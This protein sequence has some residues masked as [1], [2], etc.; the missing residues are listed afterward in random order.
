MYININHLFSVMH[1]ETISIDALIDRVYNKSRHL[2]DSTD[3]NQIV[4]HISDIISN[5]FYQPVSVDYISDRIRKYGMWKEN[6][7]KLKT[8]PVIV[9]RSDDWYACRQTLITA[10]DFAQALGEGKFGTQKQF[11]MKKAGYDD[12]PFDSN[13][14]PL[15]WGIMFEPT[16]THIYS[17]RNNTYVAEFG[18]LRHPRV[19]FLGA[20]PDGIN[21]L[22]IMLEVKC[23]YKRKINGEVPGQYYFQIQGQLD[24]CDLDECDYLECEFACI[25]TFDELQEIIKCR[26]N[27]SNSMNSVNTSNDSSTTNV[28]HGVIVEFKD[29]SF[30]YG[31]VFDG[32]GGNDMSA[33]YIETFVNVYREKGCEI[34]AV[35]I[36]ILNIFNVIRVYKNNMYLNE[37]LPL[38]GSV[39][40][41][42]LRYRENKDIYITE[43]EGKGKDT[44]VSRPAYN[45][46]RSSGMGTT[47]GK[48]P[49]A[50]KRPS[51]AIQKMSGYAFID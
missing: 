26:R 22:G 32:I 30:E 27:C 20:S 1:Q 6:L 31:N 44:K 10:S 43:V 13:L 35:N 39:W 14:P 11:Y 46:S 28:E 25:E 40:A 41:N 9:Q 23:P 51:S 19:D 24:V 34:K 4:K 21:D 45:Y 5:I 48:V 7:E 3:P 2:R 18:L 38:L 50:G 8:V 36:W 17:T 33:S 49:I 37:K 29:G 15:R 12:T 42:V 16:A 47:P